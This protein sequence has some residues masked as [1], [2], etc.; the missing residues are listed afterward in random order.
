MNQSQPPDPGDVLLVD[1]SPD[2]LF[3][4]IGALCPD[5][6]VQVLTSALRLP[7]FVGQDRQPLVVL[8]DAETQ[9]VTAIEALRGVRRSNGPASPPVV[10]LTPR[11]NGCA[12]YEDSAM[13]GFEAGASDFL[14]KPLIGALARRKV[15]FHRS[16][17][18]WRSRVAGQ[19]E[20]LR[21]QNERLAVLRARLDRAVDEG[22]GM[23]LGVHDA[24][25]ETV[26]E[27]IDRPAKA[28]S[29]PR[30]PSVEIMLRAL[31]EQGLYPETGQWDY[32]M[33]ARSSRL[34]DV[35]KLAIGD[36]ILQKP[37]RLTTAE[38][39]KVKRHTIL[40]VDMLS[41]VESRPDMG[42]Y[43]RYAKLFAGTHHE[44]W[45]GSGY[46]YGLRG[47]DIPLAGRLMAIADVYEGLTTDRPYKKAV[48]HH[49]A[50]RIIVEGRGTQFDPI[51][52]DVFA[53]VSDRFH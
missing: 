42:D 22:T 15:D 5:Y 38:F 37:A 11:G 53:Q 39:E 7:E 30:G 10:V 34:H 36:G 45:D 4:A 3:A 20:L 28:D 31:G 24:L 18:E 46:P 50:A 9:G 35:G 41:R 13:A 25:L 44:R 1:Q 6:R 12:G 16:L 33:V 2:D 21:A 19:A 49:E 43:L 26:A 8:L 48:P 47:D 27:I 23:A 32:H 17:A 51:L 40:G 14:P 52:V 29:R